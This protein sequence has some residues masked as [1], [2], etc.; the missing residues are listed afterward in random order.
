MGAPSSFHLEVPPVSRN[1][2]RSGWTRLKLRHILY[3]MLPTRS[4]LLEFKNSKW[5]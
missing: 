1:H 4:P 3:L 5:K 2:I